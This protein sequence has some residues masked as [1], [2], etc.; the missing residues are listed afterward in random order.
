V[1]TTARQ[2]PVMQN[3][4]HAESETAAEHAEQPSWKKRKI[5]TGFSAEKTFSR[6]SFL[7]I[8]LWAADWNRAL[9]FLRMLLKIDW[10]YNRT[11]I[12][13]NEVWD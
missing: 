4:K 9:I 13:S 8:S 6:S 7:Q 3:Q 10:T 1:W 5:W 12:W 2:Q 11:I